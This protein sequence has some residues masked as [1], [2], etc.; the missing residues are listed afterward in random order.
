MFI[1]LKNVGVMRQAEFE[2]GDMT[3]ICGQN[4]TGKT[5]ATYT[6]Y[7]FYSFWNQYFAIND[8]D[9]EIVETLLA[10][11][12]AKIDIQRYADSAQKLMDIACEQYSDRIADVFSTDSDHFKNSVFNICLDGATPDVWTKACS[13][14]LNTAK[15]SILSASKE[16]NSSILVVSSF[17]KGSKLNI[18]KHILKDYIS[19]AIKEILF[20]KRFSMPFIASAERTGAAIFRR[21]LNFARN[22][23]LEELSSKNKEVNPLDLLIKVR[24]EYPLPVED[25]VN[26][27]RQLETLAKDKSFIAEEYPD[28]LKDFQDI[29]G[30]NYHI[31]KNNNNDE[32]YYVPKGKKIRL[33]LDTS[34]SAVRSLLDIGFYLRHEA[35]HGA[36]IM[37]DE[38]ELNL[39]PENQRRIARLFARLLNIGIRIFITTHSDYIIRELNT[40][41]MMN[42]DK[43]YIRQIMEREGYKKEELIDAKRVRV[44]VAGESQ[45]KCDGAKRKVTC[46]TLT[47]AKIDPTYGIKVESFNETINKMNQIQ[48]DIMWGEDE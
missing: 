46:C 48:D 14:T 10:D 45:I 25:N 40:L 32:L 36:F 8:I 43:D 9:D 6:L 28:I 20:E 26:F 35:E 27:T 2:P 37:I 3:I 17:A 44:Y 38:P 13:S 4:N 42:Q 5:Y 11:G 33:S 16:Q 19:S 12:V 21:E 24:P 22:R 34:S 15:G 39:H 7:G 18:P 1:K 47:E 30:G 31:G 29:I 41:I 23:L